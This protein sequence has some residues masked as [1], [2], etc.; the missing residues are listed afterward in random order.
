M[1]FSLLGVNRG[2]VS[3]ATANRVDSLSYLNSPGRDPLFVFYQTNRVHKSGGL[4]ATL[5]GSE[6][7]SF[8]WQMYNPGLPGFDPPF[9]TDAGV[10]SSTVS[11]LQEGGYRVRIFNG[12]GT[13]T[14]LMAWVMLDD[15]YAEVEKNEEGMLPGYKYTCALLSVS[16]FVYPDTLVYYD[17]VFHEP[18]SRV[19]DF[20]F[21]WSS[22][23]SDLRIPNDTII[24][25]PNIT[26]QPPYKDTWYI[27]TATDDLGMVEVDSVF[28][29]SIQTRAEFTVE[30][31]DKVLERS[32]PPNMWDPD[33]SGEWSKDRGSTDARLTVRFRNESKN[34]TSFR[35][36]FLDTLGG[37]IQHETTY[38]LEEM[39]QFTYET[40]DK[41]YY[42]YM[43]STSEAGCEDSA[44]LEEGIYVEPSKLAIPNVFT[45]NGD[46]NNDRF[47]FV[48]Q[49]L[50]SCR[51]T[52]VDRTGK[53]V[54]KREIDDIY[55]WDGWDGNVRDSD[56]RA[57]EG[58]YYYVVEALGYDGKEY[59]DPSIWEDWSL[60]K[61]IRNQSSGS[62][63][64][65][66][67]TTPGGSG[68]EGGQKNLYTGWLYLFRH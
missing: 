11:G 10:H 62:R 40:A 19:I 27:L 33:L 39:P 49:S 17:P 66:G 29:E 4:T 36:V 3:S 28:Y 32:D 2:Q 53:V 42:P 18:I 13:D 61:S 24:L 7:Y 20:H 59:S 48:H 56:R 52:I 9:S 15:F 16:G 26:Y 31:L 65:T 43:I 5:P 8:E 25:H 60:F 35:W 46:G 55:A 58:Q 34:G 54:Y 1:L 30:Y 37:I 12:T 63:G 47:M 41:Y 14:T 57:P 23:N 68:Q 64:N 21:K 6:L 51:V 22:D 67:G 50:R 45:P 44:T 38:D